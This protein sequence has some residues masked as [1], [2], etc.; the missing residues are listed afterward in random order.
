[1]I[2]EKTKSPSMCNIRTTFFH[3]NIAV[4][5]QFT[6][7]Y[8]LYLR[9]ENRIN[10]KIYEISSEQIVQFNQQYDVNISFGIR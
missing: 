1:M 2:T 9:V 5:Q 7:S 8:W 3:G 10:L 6:H 4:L